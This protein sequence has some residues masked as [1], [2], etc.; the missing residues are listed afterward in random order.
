[1]AIRW[2]DADDGTGNLIEETTGD[3]VVTGSTMFEAAHATA[4]APPGAK[5]ARVAVQ[6]LGTTAAGE[7]FWATGLS[8]APGRSLTWSAGGYATTQT[9]RVE[10][11]LDGG[12][13]WKLAADR[14][15]TSL[16]QRAIAYDREMP[17]RVDAKYRAATVV[18]LGFSSIV[19]G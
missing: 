8:F 6:V 13:T 17:Y 11:S 9:V 5:L 19:S 18:D 3:Q 1:V 10:R 7:A 16:Y 4:L 14:V 12:S 2:Y 15:K